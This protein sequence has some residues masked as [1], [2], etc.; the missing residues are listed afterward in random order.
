MKHRLNL[1]AP[2]GAWCLLAA[3]AGCLGGGGRSSVRDAGVGG[4]GGR[5]GSG[6]A[7]G[8]GGAAGTGGSAS[9][10]GSTGTG[11]FSVGSGGASGGSGTGSGGAET[12]GSGMAGRGTGGVGPGGS[13]GR[14]TGGAG[15]GGSGGTGGVGPDGGM[16]AAADWHATLDAPIDAAVCIGLAQM[17]LGGVTW[18]EQREGTTT[19]VQAPPVAGQTSRLTITLTNSAATSFSYPGIWLTTNNAA[20]TFGTDNR[21]FTIGPGM[22][23][24]FQW[25]VKFGASVVSGTRVQ[26]RAEVVGEDVR[27][28]RCADSPTLEFDVVLQ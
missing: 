12:G 28:T 2:F 7:V 23:Q 13:A 15:T 11:G 24:P 1:F 16:D 19:W 22:S 8:S 26:F 3:A 27:R 20:A 18:S 17:S 9:A 14:A 4:T 25:Y 10:G 6:G 21:L 5:T